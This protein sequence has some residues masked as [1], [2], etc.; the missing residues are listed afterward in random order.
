MT[1]DFTALSAEQRRRDRVVIAAVVAALYGE[2]AA[3]RRIRAVP[4]H[5]AGGW[6]REGRL[7]IQAS[8]RTTAPLIRYGPDLGRGSV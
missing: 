4:V 1:T 6:V 3:I 8:H 7:A 2:P 5:P